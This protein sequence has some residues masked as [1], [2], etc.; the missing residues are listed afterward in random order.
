MIRNYN[1][2]L[3]YIAITNH[4]NNC[5]HLTKHINVEEEF[6]PLIDFLTENIEREDFYKLNEDERKSL[7]RK[8]IDNMRKD[9][10]E[11]KNDLLK[12]AKGLDKP[13]SKNK[14]KR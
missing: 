4:C 8:A 10:E 11:Q 12:M 7:V 1:N 14:L 13:N 5:D 3:S 2:Q 9:V 6:Y